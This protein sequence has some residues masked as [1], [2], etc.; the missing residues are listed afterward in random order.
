MGICK[1][2]L[3]LLLD[4]I[5]TR[6]TDV[7]KTDVAVLP[8]DVGFFMQVYDEQPGYLE[9]L[10]LNLRHWYPDSPVMCG[11]QNLGHPCCIDA[12]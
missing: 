7:K 3:G 12:R 11:F 2:Y 1:N 8:K 4:R 6:K 10:L 5:L 9:L